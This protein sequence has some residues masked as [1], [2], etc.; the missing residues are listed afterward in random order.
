LD[1]HGRKRNVALS[2]IGLVHPDGSG[3]YNGNLNFEEYD[4]TVPVLDQSLT[5]DSITI[6]NSAPS[7]F[8][9]YGASGESAVPEPATY[10]AIFGALALG[11]AG[12]REIRWRRKPRGSR[13]A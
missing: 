1:G 4:F 3:A 5:L 9:F 6:N 2:N 12:A 10:A 11:A 7:N 8:Q 13:I